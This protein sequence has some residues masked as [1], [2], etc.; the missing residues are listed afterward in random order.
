MKTGLKIWRSLENSL[1]GASASVVNRVIKACDKERSHRGVL[2]LI[3]PLCECNTVGDAHDR[4][5]VLLKKAWF[6]S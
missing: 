2:A 4:Y 6:T 1:G 3:D 5:K